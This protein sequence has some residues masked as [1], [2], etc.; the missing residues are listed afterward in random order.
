MDGT[1]TRHR[2]Q[3][4]VPAATLA[5]LE[6][7]LDSWQAEGRV[8][9]PTAAGIRAK[10]TAARRFSLSRL[11]LLLGAAFLGVGLLWLVATN[12]DEMSP[13]VRFTGVVL[14]WLSAVIGGEALAARRGPE[15]VRA[16]D[17]AVGGVRLVAALAFGAVVFQAAQSLQVPAYEPRLLGVWAAGALLQAYAVGAV[18]PLVVGICTGVG[19]YG[20]AV[21]ERADSVE[22][23]ALALLLAGALATATAVGHGVA[24][25]RR[26][27]PPWRVAG[28]LLVLSGLFVAALPRPQDDASTPT[29]LLW[30]GVALVVAASAGAAAL[31]DRVGRLEVAAA[32]VAVVLGWL[33]LLWQPPGDASV[34]QLSGEALLRQVVLVLVYLLTALWYAA[35]GVMRDAERLT[36]LAAGAL[37]LFTVVQSFAIFQ[38]ILSGAALFLSL[39]AVLVVSGFLVERGRRSLIT[40]VKEVEA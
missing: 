29:V 20:W 32:G 35:L 4:S 18:A 33:F 28:A 12:L 40:T 21:A 31:A 25:P 34:A 2:V 16:G 24:G 30:L 38:P 15:A 6:R 10:Y 11:M 13:A 27:A 5:W 8:D 9:A 23:P 3:H 17:A 1:D 39:G 26:F 14:V 7:E 37:V 36:R 22:G 19:W